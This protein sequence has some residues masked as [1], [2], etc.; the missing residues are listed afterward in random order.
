MD[1]I[2]KKIDEE[3]AI[4]NEIIRNSH[5]MELDTRATIGGLQI[6]KQIVLCEQKEP[7]E[8]TCEDEDGDT[9]ECNKCGALWTLNNGTPQDNNIRFCPECGRPIQ[10]PT[11]TH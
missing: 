1:E 2:L 5:G 11:G 3:I 8:W 7:C 10:S 6:A 4:R 9:W